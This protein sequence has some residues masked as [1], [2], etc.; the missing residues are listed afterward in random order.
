MNALLKGSLSALL[1][2]L[3]GIVSL[4]QAEDWPQWLGPN[5][6]SVWKET[7]LVEKTFRSAQ[8]H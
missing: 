1:V 8:V 4:A 3:F 2:A 6:D 7:G 5:R